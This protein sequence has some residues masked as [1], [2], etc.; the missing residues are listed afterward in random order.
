MVVRAF[1]AAVVITFT[2][3]GAPA[4]AQTSAV[5]AE[6]PPS[7]FDG[8]QYIDS[9]GCAFIRAGIGGTV[10]WVPRVNRS[11]DQICGFQPTFGETAAQPAPETTVAQAP[12]PQPS[13]VRVAPPP[14][15]VT[16]DIPGP[17]TI[18][19][20]GT[21]QRPSTSTTASASAPAPTPTPS[22]QI[23]APEPQPTEPRVTLAEA[24]EG[25]FGVQPG[26]VSAR[27]GEPINCGPAPQVASADASAPAVPQPLRLT[28]AE[29]CARAETDNIRYV[30]ATTGL[31]IVCAGPSAPTTIAQGP[32]PVPMPQ[33]PLRTPQQVA[34]S[35][36]G[37]SAN[38]RTFNG[39]PLRCGPQTQL[40]YSMSE[41]QVTRRATT[42]FLQAPPA[43][44]RTNPAIANRPAP[45]PPTGYER[46]WGDGRINHQRGLPADSALQVRAK[47]PV[48]ASQVAPAVAQPARTQ[49]QA[50]APA[51]THRFIQVGSFGDHNNADRLIQRL[52]S[53]GIPVSS[54]QSSGLKIVAAGPFRSAADLQRAMGV[55]RGM[56]FSDAYPRN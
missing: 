3:I 6:R 33:T 2:Q 36:C 52:G 8:N 43:V 7:S 34:S 16:A 48:P 25:R 45:Q 11:R 56:G 35:A 29:V 21:G 28:L 13:P 47:P 18:E 53:Q 55:V 41:P 12:E 27:T 26:F 14:S 38:M 44:L 30:N 51:L 23:I 17:L 46:V 42:P 1:V 31:P 4:L 54:G 49:P 39:L 50:T 10:N 15:G 22:P 20:P 40:P 32:M 19:L 5:P 24:C 37:N 9:S